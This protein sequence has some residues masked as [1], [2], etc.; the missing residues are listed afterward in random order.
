VGDAK[1]FELGEAIGELGVMVDTAGFEGGELLLQ[2]GGDGGYHR[3]GRR[4]VG[5]QQV[6][7]FIDCHGVSCRCAVSIGK[8]TIEVIESAVHGVWDELEG[9]IHDTTMALKMG[10]V[11]V[12]KMGFQD[13]RNPIPFVSSKEDW[14]QKN[15]NWG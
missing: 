15:R 12:R 2:H 10:I 8:S 11:I 1:G 13:R 14:D 5:R 4:L 7:A 9:R 3:C 6:E